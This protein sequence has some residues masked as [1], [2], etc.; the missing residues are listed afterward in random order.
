M[1][2]TIFLG[3]LCWAAAGCQNGSSGGSATVVRDSAGVRI[4]E[5]HEP[6]WALG[7]GWKVDLTPSTIIGT[8]DG[9]PNELLYDVRGTARLADGRILVLNGGSF[10][11]RFYGSDGRFVASV[12]GQGGGAG[13][14]AGFPMQLLAGFGDTLSVLDM[15]SWNVVRF[16]GGGAFIDRRPLDR[17]MV[18]TRVPKGYHSE[19]VFLLPEGGFM[20]P[21]H[22]IPPR[23]EPRGYRRPGGY[24]VVAST[25]EPAF[26]QPF[27]SN[28]FS[29]PGF[30]RSSLFA[31]GQAKLALGDNAIYDVAIYT[32]R[33]EMTQRIRNL[34][35]NRPVLPEDITAIRDRLVQSARSPEQAAEWALDFDTA[36]KAE[37][38]PAFSALLI[39]RAGHL[40]VRQA[41][42]V[43]ADADTPVGWDIYDPDGVFLGE[44]PLPAGLNLH[45]VG[46]DYILGV[47][48]DLLGVESVHLHALTRG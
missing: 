28:D 43:Q 41:S 8:A 2:R 1:S 16:D 7:E 34:R 33:G 46:E 15:P 14:F 5:N 6:V 19:R 22:E 38:F 3:L 35:P 47:R 18:T 48:Y 9:N 13:E 44:I 24:L 4:V 36:D 20:A 45:D 40:W 37:T 11:L 23:P 32:P 31:V 30:A 25:A 42:Q 21:V 29:S 17:S 39:D 12:G 10:E 26:L 27:P